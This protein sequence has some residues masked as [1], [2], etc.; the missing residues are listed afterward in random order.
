MASFVSNAIKIDKDFLSSALG[1][2]FEINSFTISEGSN[3][4]DNYMSIIYS[5]DIEVKSKISESPSETKHLL[6]KC[7]PTHPARQGFLIK[8][9][10]F[11]RELQMY[12]VWLVELSRLQ[13]EVIGLQKP[14]DLPFTRVLLGNSV[15]FTTQQCKDYI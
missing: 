9:N 8:S 2:E 13:K 1:N 4:G 5:V 6:V 14:F 3:V 11:H 10:F 15:D 12:Q 7:F